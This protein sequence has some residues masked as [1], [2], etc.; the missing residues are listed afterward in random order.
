MQVVINITEKEI[1]F[2]D[3]TLEELAKYLDENVPE[4]KQFKIIL[5]WSVNS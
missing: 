1:V 4:Y 3:P 2:I 5:E